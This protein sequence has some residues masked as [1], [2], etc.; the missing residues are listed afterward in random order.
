MI[1]DNF[2]RQTYIMNLKPV[3][4][5]F[6]LFILCLPELL[7]SQSATHKVLNI[8]SSIGPSL[9]APGVISTQYTEWSTSFTPDK[10]T[11]YTSRGAVYL[12]II[13]SKYL[14]AAWQTPQVVSFSGRWRDTDPFVTPDG[15]KLFYF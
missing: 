3:A 4:V 7:L 2:V 6:T 11:V 12:T 1:I 14:N 15:K 5:Y 8:D 9:F 10:K 13:S